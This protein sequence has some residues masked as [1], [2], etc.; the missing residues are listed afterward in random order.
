MCG[1]R[2]CVA[3]RPLVFEIAG[4]TVAGENI[5]AESV[6][7]RPILVLDGKS[8]FKFITSLVRIAEDAHARR[9][10]ESYPPSC[11][12]AFRYRSFHQTTNCACVS[13]LTHIRFSSALGS[14]PK[15]SGFSY[16]LTLPL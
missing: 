6:S 13:W 4:E 2:G 7:L 10:G 8:P 9:C 12:L 14:P 15:I 11:A 5:F 3:L 1:T 16:H